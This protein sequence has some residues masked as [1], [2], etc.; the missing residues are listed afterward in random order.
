MSRQYPVAC[1]LVG[2]LLLLFLGIAVAALIAIHLNELP[3]VG[4]SQLLRVHALCGAF[5]ML[6]ASVASIRKYY[7]TLISDSTAR[8]IGNDTNQSSWDFGWVF[9]YFTRP[10]LGGI[11]GALAYTLAFIGFQ[12]LS[13]PNISK[14]SNQGNM[15]LYA[16][17]LVSGY[18]VSDVLD[19]F[20]LIAK[21]LFS[22]RTDNTVT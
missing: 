19:R 15:L 3:F 21:Q 22:Q 8:S 14:I 9:Y 2:V 7:K 4:R 18:A 1:Y 12:I 6:G 13:G 16:V 20:K 11:L 10:I 5:G 17:S